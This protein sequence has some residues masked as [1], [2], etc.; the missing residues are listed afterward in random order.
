MA[1]ASRETLHICDWDMR[2]IVTTR[3]ESLPAFSVTD[4][5]NG[6]WQEVDQW[7][8]GQQEVD[9][10]NWGWQGVDQQGVDQ[11]KWGWQEVDQ[12]NWRPEHE[13]A[14]EGNQWRRS[15]DFDLP[16][17]P[18]AT[19]ERSQRRLPRPEAGAQKSSLP[20]SEVFSVP[21]EFS[22]RKPWKELEQTTLMLRNLPTTYSRDH[23]C[24]LM[25]HHGF[26]KQFDFV[27]VPVDLS[28]K[29]IFGYAFVNFVTAE[30]AKR[31]CQVF[32]YFSGWDV[33][34]DK[35]CEVSRSELQGLHAHIERYQNSPVMHETVPDEYRPAIFKQG[36]RVDFP[37][38]TKKPRVPRIRR[39]QGA[40]AAGLNGSSEAQE[41]TTCIPWPEIGCTRKAGGSEDR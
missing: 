1:Y 23:V 4:Q 26:A 20:W 37:A 2:C 12:W 28:S 40:A 30:A 36:L 3:K 15:K 29:S 33:Q 16:R 34:S 17:Q 6:G 25:S 11:W 10:W 9:Q 35:V 31:C 14:A 27:Y 41:L 18:V 5:W 21:E 24:D 22:T 8:S 13:Q 7:N 39:R 38:P 19:A 32:Q